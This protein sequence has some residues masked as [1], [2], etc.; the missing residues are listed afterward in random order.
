MTKPWRCWLFRWNKNRSVYRTPEK[1]VQSWFCYHF[2][3]TVKSFALSWELHK[4]TLNSILS[5]INKLRTKAGSG[6]SSSSVRLFSN[7]RWL[8]WFAQASAVSLF[9][10]AS[11]IVARHYPAWTQRFVISWLTITKT[12][13]EWLFQFFW[14]KNDEKSNFFQSEAGL[15][16]ISWSDDVRQL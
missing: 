15:I 3:F 8:V 13:M 2:M 9:K 7:C 5:A 16:K 12:L 1:N 10:R 11:Q 4:T 6:S 14:K